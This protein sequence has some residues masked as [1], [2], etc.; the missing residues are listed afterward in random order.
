MDEDQGV[1]RV[2]RATSAERALPKQHASKRL[3]PSITLCVTICQSGQIFLEKMFLYVRQEVTLYRPSLPGRR[4]SRDADALPGFATERIFWESIAMSRSPGLPI[5]DD[6]VAG[7]N[8]DQNA[9]G[10]LYEACRPYLLLVANQELDAALAVKGG[11]SDIVQET[12]L[13][14]H[15]GF[16]RFQGETKADLLAWLRVL[17]QNNMTDHVRRYRKA[18]MRRVDNEVSIQG[19]RFREAIGDALAT[20]QSPS[21]E[22]INAEQSEAVEAALRRLPE[23]SRRAIIL[24]NNERR[25]F[26]EIGQALGKSEEAARKLWFR[27]VEQLRCDLGIGHGP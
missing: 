19:D 27:A 13:D 22:L 8:G 26:A 20:T 14:A 2:S 5:R 9:L 1:R 25:S 11:A 17:L 21:R 7:L 23:A 6:V 18:A 4:K 3:T 15:R 24:R 16:A 10:R 12:F